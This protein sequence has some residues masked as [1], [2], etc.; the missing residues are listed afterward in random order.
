MKNVFTSLMLLVLIAG[1]SKSPLQELKA[2]GGTDDSVMTREEAQYWVN[3]AMKDSS[4]FK[5]AMDFC[6]H[7]GI[8]RTVMC[9]QL[10][11][12]DDDCEYDKQFEPGQWLKT[13]RKTPK[14]HCDIELTDDILNR[15]R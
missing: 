2:H 7:H 8:H 10:Q 5:E 14:A 13:F 15:R 1:C 12:I 9:Y 11:Q 4:T 6:F 3:E